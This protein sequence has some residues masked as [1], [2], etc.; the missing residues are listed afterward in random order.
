[1]KIFGSLSGKCE[2]GQ[3]H[4]RGSS[5]CVPVT[6]L[7]DGSRDCLRGDDEKFCNRVLSPECEGTVTR[8]RDWALNC[9]D[10]L[11][12]SKTS[13]TSETYHNPRILLLDRMGIKGLSVFTELK[14]RM[15]GR[16]IAVLSMEYNSLGKLFHLLSEV[17]YLCRIQ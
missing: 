14:T 13:V 8:R 2:E 6:S 9:T 3:Y 17:L 12:P 5:T 1:M 15:S 16:Y 7:C 10:N 11:T 4:C